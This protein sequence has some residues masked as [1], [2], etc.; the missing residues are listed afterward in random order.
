MA[1]R[2]REP[3]VPEWLTDCFFFGK[4]GCEKKGVEY[5]GTKDGLGWGDSKERNRKERK[6]LYTRCTH[7]GL[8]LGHESAK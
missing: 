2:E 7:G 3:R 1:S 8:R 6:W 5:I 4:R